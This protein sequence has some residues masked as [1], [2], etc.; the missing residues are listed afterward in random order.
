MSLPNVE[1]NALPDFREG[2]LGVASVTNPDV[3]FKITTANK[4]SFSSAESR[5]G[6]SYDRS[7]NGLL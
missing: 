6:D 1:G 4:A 5:C 7:E 3:N 2:G